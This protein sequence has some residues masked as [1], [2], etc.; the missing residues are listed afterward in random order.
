[1]RVASYQFV[2]FKLLRAAMQA[3][4]GLCQAISRAA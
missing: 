4:P 2:T 3:R 1:M